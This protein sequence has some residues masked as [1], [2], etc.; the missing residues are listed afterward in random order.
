MIYSDDMARYDTQRRPAERE[1]EMCLHCG[2]DYSCHH[3]WACDPWYDGVTYFDDLSESERYSTQSM[4]D[5][6][7]PVRKRSVKQILHDTLGPAPTPVSAG[8]DLSD[9]RTW[10]RVGRD[11]SH[12]D[13]GIHRQDCT[14]HRR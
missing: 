8:A 3:G 11:P 2:E 13:C 12:C 1:G 10:A 4:R 9:W 6:I 7:A 5:S 14:Y